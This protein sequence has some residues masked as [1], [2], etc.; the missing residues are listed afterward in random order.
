MEQAN[1]LKIAI[2]GYGQEGEASYEY[3]NKL[4]ADITI[5][6]ESIPDRTAPEGVKTYFSADAFSQMYD[7]DFIIRTPSL[8]PVK[9][10]SNSKVWSATNEFFM[11]CPAPI[12]GVTGTKGKG[13]TA[14]LIAAILREGGKQVHL[15][16][17]IGKPALSELEH[18][19]AED[20]VVF[21]LSSF[22]LWDLEK[23]P[24]NAV[25]LMIEPDHL[26][27]HSSMEDYVTAK[28]HI[29]VFQTSDDYLTYHPTNSF[30]A[31]IAALSPAKKSRYMS[32]D[33]ANVVDGA[34]TIENQ[35]ICQV[36]EVGL[37]GAH[38]LENICAVITASWRYIKDTEAIKKAVTSFQGLPHR[39]QII[40]EVDGVSYVDDSY[41]SAPG[42][43]IAAITSF[44]QPEI[45]ICGGFSRDLDFTQL[46]KKISEQQ[47][48]K[49]VLLIGQTKQKIAEALQAQDFTSFQILD[50]TN[51][52]EIVAAA[53]HESTNGDVVLLSPGCPSFDMFKNFADRGEQFQQIV[54]GL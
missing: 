31:Q 15:V 3:W 10:Q 40:E 47:N 48:I 12:I 1:K 16:G 2:A 36:S 17:N 5:F 52:S 6:D 37:L 23:S 38:N 30:S 32:S 27:V 7:F 45:L 11:Q 49:K 25:V 9:I 4:G 35:T 26:D 8:S 34:I 50:A 22:Q 13:T 21:E 46:A 24:Q 39:L 41:S 18:I 33:G 14:S 20:F 19:Q 43:V 44:Q 29:A 28:S 54:K 51:M 42:A 53:Q